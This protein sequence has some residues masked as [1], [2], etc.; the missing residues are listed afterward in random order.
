MKKDF[1]KKKYAKYALV[2]WFE[3]NSAFHRITSPSPYSQN[4]ATVP[5]LR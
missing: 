5:I 3:S 2:S 1:E 4:P